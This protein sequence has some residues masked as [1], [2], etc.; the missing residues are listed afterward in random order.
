VAVDQTPE[1]YIE[2]NETGSGVFL[3]LLAGGGTLVSFQE[4]VTYA[5]AQRHGEGY[6]A[7]KWIP[8]TV[9]SFAA[10]QGSICPIPGEP[11]EKTCTANGCICSPATKT[12]VDA[13]QNG[14]GGGES[15]GDQLSHPGAGKK[16]RVQDRGK[17][18]E[19]VKK[20]ED[21]LITV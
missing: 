11:C 16:T 12:C 21:D 20:N 3:N 8:N 10:V 14:G 13:S 1:A 18:Q 5:E 6:A 9:A 7:F 2:M 15:G 4:N 19:E 17:F